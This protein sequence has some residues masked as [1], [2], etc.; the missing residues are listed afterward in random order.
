MVSNNDDDGELSGSDADEGFDEDMES[1]RRACI[2][3]GTD[4][5]SLQPSSAT[6]TADDTTA[7][8]A[9]S[10]G[11]GA[12]DSEA[13]LELVREIQQRFSACTQAEMPLFLKPLNTLPPSVSDDDEDDFETLRAIKRR[14]AGYDKGNSLML[15]W[16]WFYW[17]D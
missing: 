12:S 17:F 13:D 6:S 15:A 5:N 4:L 9:V 2:L 16:N 10:G 3:T 1:L 7:G 8:T 14:F 11:G